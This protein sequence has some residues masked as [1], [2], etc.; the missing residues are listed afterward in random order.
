VI[1]SIQSGGLSISNEHSEYRWAEI[2]E[3]GVLDKADWFS[4]Y[5]QS[6]LCGP[7]QKPGP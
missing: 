6:Y 1:A 5:Y 4:M 2:N 3:L 7:D